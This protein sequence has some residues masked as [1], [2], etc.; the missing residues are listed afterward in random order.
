VSRAIVL[1]TRPRG[2]AAELSRL[3]ELAGFST[4]EAPAIAIDPAWDPVELDAVRRDLGAGAFTWVVLPSQNAGHGLE[5]RTTGV[6]CGAATARA[7]GIDADVELERFSASAALEL[8]RERVTPGQRVLVPR[9]AEGRD[10]LIDGLSAL[11]AIVDAPL[12][13][14]TLPVEDAAARLRGGGIDVVVL[15]SPSA[16]TSVVGAV[17]PGTRV[18]CLGGTTASAAAAAGMRVD[19]VAR[20]TGM[21]ALVDAVIAA[22]AEVRV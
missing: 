22:T 14:R 16:V 11:G 20:S 15:C 12:A 3:L 17:Q 2:Q 10:E 5:L 8:L 18:V 21:A 13:Y 9:A 1:N 7:L 19:G 6:V 4:V